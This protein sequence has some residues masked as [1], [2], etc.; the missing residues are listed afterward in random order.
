MTNRLAVSARR[1]AANRMRV[2]PEVP[3]C[4]RGRR[5]GRRGMISPAPR[6]ARGVR[7]AVR[8]RPRR[9]R[10][11]QA[12]TRESFTSRS[13][14][15]AKPG[16]PPA[17]RATSGRIHALRV[18][19]PPASGRNASHRQRARAASRLAMSAPGLTAVAGTI[20]E[21]VAIR[22]EPAKDA[23]NWAPP[24]AS[25]A[26]STPGNGGMTL[27]EGQRAGMTGM[28]ARASARW[29]AGR[30]L[31]SETSEVT[32]GLRATIPR[33]TSAPFHPGLPRSRRAARR[34]GGTTSVA[35]GRTA[36]MRATAARRSV[37]R[38]TWSVA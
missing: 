36:R 5:T 18:R 13:S 33:V 9:W 7:S 14:S 4:A 25:A 17:R 19:C 22:C 15:D 8:T 30:P 32:T 26:I 11:S 20:R 23:S 21:S 35:R 2:Q 29:V 28:K 24:R 12:R 37:V 1:V 31:A 38:R 3:D 10:M 16:P 27:S 34:T 6:C